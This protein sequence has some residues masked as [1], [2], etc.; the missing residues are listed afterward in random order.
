MKSWVVALH[1][2]LVMS[3]L[4]RGAHQ[5]SSLIEAAGRG[6][7]KTVEKLIAQHPASVVKGSEEGTRALI[8]AAGSNQKEIVAVLLAHGV[9][10]NGRD[11][12]ENLPL[13]W[14]GAGGPGGGAAP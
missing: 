5:E 7:L 4:A 3:A 9:D 11:T 6:D 14:A 8:R 10:P 12:C 13:S 2:A 1:I